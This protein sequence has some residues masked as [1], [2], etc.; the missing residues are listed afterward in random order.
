MNAHPSQYSV[1][2]RK[3]YGNRLLDNKS[4]SLSIFGKKIKNLTGIWLM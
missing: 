2:L 1:K 3:E 4:V